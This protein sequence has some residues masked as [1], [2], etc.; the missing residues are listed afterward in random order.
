MDPAMTRAFANQ[1]TAVRTHEGRIYS[2]DELQK[3]PDVDPRHPLVH[4]WALRKKTAERIVSYSQT[5][6]AQSVLDVG[7]GNGWASKLIAKS[8]LSVTAIDVNQPELEQA[9][10]VF[11]DSRNLQFMLMDPARGELPTGPFDLVTLMSS[12]QYFSDITGLIH[13]LL[14]CLQHE[15]CILIADTPFYSVEEADQARNRSHDYYTGI[16]YPEFADNY[17]HHT[18]PELR[19]FNPQLIYDPRSWICRFRRQVLRH[20]VVPFPMI[21]IKRGPT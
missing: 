8:G 20:V 4:E 9:K 5:I 14:S 16:G 6:G 10:R 12:I 21:V 2:D 17:H 15:G 3:L 7:C 13:R 1:Y 11:A 19:P 18:W